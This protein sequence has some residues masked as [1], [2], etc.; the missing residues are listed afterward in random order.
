M[1]I[2]AVVAGFAA[3][4]VVGASLLVRKSDERFSHRLTALIG[5]VVLSYLSAWIPDL[6]VYGVGH[7]VFG[8]IGMVLVNWAVICAIVL[9]LV[10]VAAGR[11]PPNSRLLSDASVSALRASSSAPKPGR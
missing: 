11:L 6:F 10:R 1:G 5:G 4:I 3:M 9:L 8:E 2:A 7:A